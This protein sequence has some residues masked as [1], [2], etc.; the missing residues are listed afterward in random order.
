MKTPP[1]LY[2][3]PE[4]II[5][6]RIVLR[7][8][9]T[10]DGA[11]IWETVEESREHIK[12]WMAWVNHNNSLADSEE[13][14][15]SAHARW[16]QR[17]SLAMGIWDAK[18]DRLLGQCGLV[19]PDWDIPSIEVGYWLRSTALGQGYVTE[20]VRLAVS[21]AFDHLGMQRVHLRCDALNV[22]SAAVAERSG[23]VL[24]GRLRNDDR[25]PDGSELRDTLVYGMT[26]DD[27]AKIGSA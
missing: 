22:R 9:K 17:E 23:F 11:A 13:Y 20:A 16:I 12:V 27:Y 21:M 2:D 25:S 24:E 3:V 8:I 5:G 4:E 7:S 6:E 26:R 19:R 10:G 1:I 14:A 15:R 18:A